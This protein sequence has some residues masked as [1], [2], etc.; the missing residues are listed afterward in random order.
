MP[1]EESSALALYFRRRRV[2]RVSFIRCPL[3]SLAAMMVGQPAGRKSS[4]L[5]FFVA[6]QSKPSAGWC[7][8]ATGSA[9]V[10]EQ[11]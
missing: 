7:L 5:H 4:R 10:L 3:T 1:I 11:N 8:F 2:Y 6:C 9:V